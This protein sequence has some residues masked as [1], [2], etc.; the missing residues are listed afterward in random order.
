MWALLGCST[1]P[2]AHIVY[3]CYSVQRVCIPY[4]PY[5]RCLCTLFRSTS[6]RTMSALHSRAGSPKTGTLNSHDLHFGCLQASISSGSRTL[7]RSSQDNAANLYRMS[8]HDQN[9]SPPNRSDP[10]K[11]YKLQSPPSNISPGHYISL[12]AA[13]SDRN[14]TDGSLT[15]PVELKRSGSCFLL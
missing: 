6:L 11:S 1:L 10:Y 7:D 5:I 13:K 4:P 9:S 14:H 3:V 8:A 2:S 12:T 15:R